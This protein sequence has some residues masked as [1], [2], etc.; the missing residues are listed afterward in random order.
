M[1]RDENDPVFKGKV[2]LSLKELQN[3]DELWLVKVPKSVRFEFD[4]KSLMTFF[5]N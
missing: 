5:K 2:N 4:I 1:N 3:A